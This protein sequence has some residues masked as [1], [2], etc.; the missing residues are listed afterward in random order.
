MIKK[1]NA[2]VQKQQE[3]KMNMASVDEQVIKDKTPQEAQ[4]GIDNLIN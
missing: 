3:D 2:Q 1:A 4:T